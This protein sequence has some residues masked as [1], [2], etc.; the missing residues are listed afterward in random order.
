MIKWLFNLS[1]KE[2]YYVV[3]DCKTGA[4]LWNVNRD[5]V[6]FYDRVLRAYEPHDGMLVREMTA[7][8]KRE[9]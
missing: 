4:R 1:R 7:A 9:H 2:A 5:G 3:E 8:E 6:V